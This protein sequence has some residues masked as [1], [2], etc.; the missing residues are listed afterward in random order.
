MQIVFLGKKMNNFLG[1]KRGQDMPSKD[2]YY[3]F[4]KNP[5]NAWSR[6]LLQ[7]VF[8]VTD[9]FDQRRVQNQFFNVATEPARL[10]LKRK[11]SDNQ[12][13]RFILPGD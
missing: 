4:L 11:P 5:T 8:K 1:S 13:V 10:I 9:V 3:R 7:L 2:T 12:G 6:F